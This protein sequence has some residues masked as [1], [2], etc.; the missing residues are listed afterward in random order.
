[1]KLF[2]RFLLV[3]VCVGLSAEE[4][5]EKLFS[6]EE[7]TYHANELSDLLFRLRNNPLNINSA[8]KKDLLQLPW[9]AE[10][11][12]DRILLLRR[13]TEINSLWQLKEIGIDEVTLSDIREFISLQPATRIRGKQQ[14]R[15]EYN[16][17]KKKIPSTLKYYQSQNFEFGNF[18]CG[19]LSQKDEGEKNLL[20]FYSYY[21]QYQSRNAIQNLI[22]GKYRLALGQGIVFAPK[23]GLSKSSAATT[24]PVKR[25]RNVVPY[26]SSFEIWELQGSAA[27]IKYK[28]LKLIPYVSSN[29]LSANLNEDCK[30][31]AF[32]ESG[33]H[34]DPQ[35]RKN[36][37]ESIWGTA[38]QIEHQKH[39][40]GASFSRFRF[41]HEFNSGHLS[42][43]SAANIF[44]LSQINNFP[45][46]GEA[47]LIEDKF[48]V[49]LGFKFG[50]QRLRQLLVM[51]YYEKNLPTW[52]G[53]PFSTQSRFD[54][55]M[56]IYYGLT[57]LPFAKNQINLY[58][59]LWKYPE[60][61]YFE[62]MPTVGS[63][64]FLQWES[65]WGKNVFRLSL[66]HKFKEKYIS[67]EESK[68]RDSER[69]M[70]RLEWRQNL[71]EFTFKS[72]S[73]IVFESLPEDD[74]NQKGMLFYEQIRWQ[75]NQFEIVGQ[76]T[77]FF[78]STYPFNLRHYVY[79]YN[80]DGIMQNSVFSGDGAA[81]YVLF[82]YKVLS[83]VELQ[84]KISDRLRSADNLRLYFQIS[85][86][87]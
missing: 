83:P 10:E 28:N 6:L 29:H 14:F 87:W 41:D 64:Q 27:E 58:L 34:L 75:K 32:N 40:V 42:E 17:K 70:I 50:E 74:V 69:T 20:D 12:V 45:L 11:D 82:K 66:Q 13:K 47:A 78:T 18:R 2:L 44:F 5:E 7:E 79:E 85:A 39:Q 72:R 31:T 36:V 15:V 76:L 46:F 59:D 57:F 30:I 71:G 23:L 56:G 49:I 62:K 8:G 48:G 24:V 53:N 43:Y 86:N 73:E 1:M 81:F 63:E 54:N 55:E 84:A 33:L 9:L 38:I 4:S 61:R 16:Q 52:H 65:H 37:V 35:K 77:T 19:F 67:L 21:L 22:M 68:I 80:V 25:F 26:T 60:T 51:R 3:F